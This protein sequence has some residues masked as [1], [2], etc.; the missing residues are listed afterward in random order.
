MRQSLNSSLR[1]FFIRGG[2][3]VTKALMVIAIFT[4]LVNIFGGI[5]LIASLA[6]TIPSEQPV[7]QL[8]SLLVRPWSLITYPLISPPSPLAVLFAVIWLWFVG[9]SLE[10]RWGSKAFAGFFGWISVLTASGALLA[11]LLSGRPA[12]LIGLWVPLA[13]LTVAWAALNPEAQVM[14]YLVIPLKAK[15][16][17]MISAAF[18]YLYEGVS[19]HP[20]FGIFILTGCAV[21]YYQV[22]IG[23]IENKRARDIRIYPKG[24]ALGLLE[25]FA[26]WRRKKRLE[27]LFKNSGFDD[28]NYR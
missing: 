2:M 15:Y 18:L 12:N 4:M 24:K 8:A 21:A 11:A 20:V 19:I 16:L 5:H 28:K 9:S 23:F 7:V 1:D 14:F 10:R 6:F 22:L 17:A 25:R 26:E 3:P 13:P 27:K